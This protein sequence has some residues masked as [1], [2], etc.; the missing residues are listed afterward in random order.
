M[1]L[2][3]FLRSISRSKGRRKMEL[4]DAELA[5]GLVQQLCQAAAERHLDVLNCVF[6][7]MARYL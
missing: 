2:S 1:R 6:L 3:E 7:D 5:D 4:A